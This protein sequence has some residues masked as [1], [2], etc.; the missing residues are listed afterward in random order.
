MCLFALLRLTLR[1]NKCL[2]SSGNNGHKQT[3][4]ID[5]DRACVSCVGALA[6]KLT[7]DGDIK[8]NFICIMKRRQNI[9]FLLKLENYFSQSVPT[10]A[11]DAAPAYKCS[12]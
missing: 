3:A 10:Q 4:I 7:S 1:V 9:L 12:D 5:I 2:H 11:E 6:I 8:K